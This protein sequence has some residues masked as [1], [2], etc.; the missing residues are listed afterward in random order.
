VNLI[1]LRAVAAVDAL[2]VAALTVVSR[3]H[4][5]AAA[6]GYL[7][8]LIGTILVHRSPGHRR[9]ARALC[10]AGLVPNTLGAVAAARASRPASIYVG[11]GGAVI[12]V[13]YLAAL[14][15]PP[16]P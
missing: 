11:V 4:G 3:P 7:P 1:A 9:L 16:H 2:N 14:R 13:G 5:A 12:G 6:A 10:V 8:A 15:P